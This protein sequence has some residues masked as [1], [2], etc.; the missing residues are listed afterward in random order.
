MTA[1][2]AIRFSSEL[3]PL[4]VIGCFVFAPV[5][6]VELFFLFG[7]SSRSWRKLLKFCLT[8]NLAA[9]LAAVLFFSIF[10]LFDINPGLLCWLI[11]IIAVILTENAV[12]NK[13]WKIIHKKKFIFALTIISLS[14]YIIASGL[15]SVFISSAAKS[16][17]GNRLRCTNNLK[18]IGLALLLYFEDYKEFPDKSGA[19]GLEKL[20]ADYLSGR[21]QVFHCPSSHSD[22]G[23]NDKTPLKELE[24]D[25]IYLSGLK[26][27]DN[28]KHDY[29]KI[30]M[31]WDKP[32]NHK[33]YGNVLFMDGH[34][35]S[36]FGED[37]MEQAGIKK[38]ANR[39]KE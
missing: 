25:Y 17:Y 11:L 10:I 32:D 5:I 35:E 20:R 7:Y 24:L 28:K 8:A 15:I 16:Q 34:V 4:L 23:E 22:I 27:D 21:K 13:I 3:F 39:Q 36:F 9:L 19:T 29:S 1:Y 14:A 18:Q 33:N 38:N 26:V 37:W 6:I 31:V 30:P 2:Q 12:Y